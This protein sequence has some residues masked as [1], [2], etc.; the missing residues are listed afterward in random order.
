MIVVLAV[1]KAKL[2]LLYV[3]NA[4][5][6]SLNKNGG[7]NVMIKIG[8]LQVNENVSSNLFLILIF[9]SLLLL[10][11]FGR[12]FMLTFINTRD[13]IKVDAT[14]TDV[15]YDFTYEDGGN[16]YNYVKLK[17]VYNNNTYENKQRVAFRFNKKVGNRIEIYV[18]PSNANEVRNNFD[19]RISIVMSVFALVIHIFMIKF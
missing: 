7:K 19:F 17:Y 10:I 5:G 14:I 16:T 12:N 15:S 6:Q 11:I 9:F 4:K 18:N 1:K 3:V 2:A 8:K 13:Y